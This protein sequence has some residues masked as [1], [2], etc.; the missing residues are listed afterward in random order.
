MNRNAAEQQDLD[1][2]GG[3][4]LQTVKNALQVEMQAQVMDIRG[5]KVAYMWEIGAKNRGM[6]EKN[7]CAVGIVDNFL[8]ETAARVE[9]NLPSDM[10]NLISVETGS[11]KRRL[12]PWR[13]CLPG[14]WRWR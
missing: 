7:L 12:S 1:N 13:A 9:E 8:T 11:R 10:E 5:R 14:A 4:P 2:V 6:R 3:N